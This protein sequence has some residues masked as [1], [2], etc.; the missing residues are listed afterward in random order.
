MASPEA[1]AFLDHTYS[2]TGQQITLAYALTEPGLASVMVQPETP[3]LLESLSEAVER[4]LPAGVA[5]QI[6]IARFA[7][8]ARQSVA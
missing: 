6:E 3:A 7:A 1:Y 4:E 2:W 5:A 8:T